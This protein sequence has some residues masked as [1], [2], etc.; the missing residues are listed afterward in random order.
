MKGI[1]VLQ[2]YIW[3]GGGLDTFTGG[4]E[5]KIGDECIAVANLFATDVGDGRAAGDTLRVLVDLDLALGILDF[6]FL[7]ELIFG[8]IQRTTDE[9]AA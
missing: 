8:L 1:A 2:H 4:N 6:Q 3:I 9:T 5:A 7:V